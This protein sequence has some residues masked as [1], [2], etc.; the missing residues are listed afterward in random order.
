MKRLFSKDRSLAKRTTKDNVNTNSKP[1]QFDI[2]VTFTTSSS[3]D[4]DVYYEERDSIEVSLNHD[5]EARDK[6]L[7]SERSFEK[8]VSRSSK[9]STSEKGK[10]QSTSKLPSTT[11]TTKFSKLVIFGGNSKNRIDVTKKKK[12]SSASFG[13]KS[14]VNDRRL[15][16]AK[17]TM[18]PRMNSTQTAST[19]FFSTI[20]VPTSNK[21]PT[22][23][24]ESKIFEYVTIV[25]SSDND[26]S[27]DDSTFT[28]SSYIYDGSSAVT[29]ASSAIDVI[30]NGSFAKYKTDIERK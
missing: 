20:T 24:K 18:I 3:C 16:D 13:L 30:P 4:S 28:G 23:E 17:S 27:I 2:V 7:L 10:V 29:T 12:V 14:T 22:S 5:I 26:S 15:H 8:K 19:N 6:T 1:N 21:R 9:N 25:Q 11:K